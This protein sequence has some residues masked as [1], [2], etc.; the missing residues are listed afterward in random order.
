MLSAATDLALGRPGARTA[1]YLL[2]SWWAKSRLPAVPSPSLG[3]VAKVAADEAFRTLMVA[4]SHL[5][6]RRELVV[7]RDELERAAELFGER[8]WQDRPQAYHVEPPGLSSVLSRRE[9]CW[10]LD[11][12][13]IRFVSG[14]EPHEGE[15]GR[16]RWLS[17]KPVRTA[18]AWVLRHRGHARPW[19]VCVH[20]Y[21]MG[22]PL[23]DFTAFRA[24]WL[25]E[26]LGLNVVI[27]VLP[28]HGERKIGKRSGDGF[29]TA[30]FMDTVH[31]EAQAIWD[32][33]RILDWIRGQ[34]GGERLGVYGISLGGY[35]AAL[36]AGF[37]GNLDCIV[38]GMPAI[39][40]TA[41]LRIHAPKRLLRAA[42]A[43]GIRWETAETVARVIS[44]L[45]VRPL[46]PRERRFLFAGA[47]DRLIPRDHIER[48]WRH[49]ER[50]ALWWF[51]GS[52]LSF[53]WETDKINSLLA[54]ALRQSGLLRL[55]AGAE[56]VESR[57][58]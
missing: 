23:A 11:Y 49:W 37:D 13:H 35:T 54:R 28:L 10:G 58:A 30:A 5:P 22:F 45:G 21:R 46:V 39:S 4:M 31:A 47:A 29:F 1:L 44:P 2:E 20:G 14:Y 24:R 6:S 19:L 17:Y 9:R 18:H 38:A 8:G 42:E 43:A 57:A 55:G 51:E 25:H 7:I 3:L 26:E 56:P 32:L 36:L 16:E 33:R 40:L 41:L 48:L 53:T 12:D 34:E 27:P 15:P 52:H 50:P